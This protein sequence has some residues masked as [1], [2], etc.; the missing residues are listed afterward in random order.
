MRS[1][2]LDPRSDPTIDPSSNPRSDPGSDRSMGG[3]AMPWL[4]AL[5]L[6][7]V[8]LGCST[9]G[10]SSS[11]TVAANDD[12]LRAV[13]VDL[14]GQLFLRDGHGIGSYDAFVIPPATVEYARSSLR[15]PEEMEAGFLASLEQS[16]IDAS[17]DAG[18]P[19]VDAPGACVLRIGLGFT[20]VR[21]ER[22]RSDRLGEVVLV[23][24]FQDTLT[25]QPLLRYATEHR[26]ERDGTGAP[27]SDQLALAFDDMVAELNVARALRAAGLADEKVRPGCHGTLAALGRKAGAPAVSAGPDAR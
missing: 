24:E 2:T 3:R 10:G 4:L 23:M 27:L 18:I 11:A 20:D 5:V 17:D 6:S 12:G 25:G 1:S 15:L 13:S 14:P 19:I 26:I 22:A 21:I 9:S 8:A 16:L 7:A